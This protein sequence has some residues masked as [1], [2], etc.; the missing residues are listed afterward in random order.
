VRLVS[1]LTDGGL[2]AGVV[3]G[4]RVVEARQAL[5]RAGHA[6]ADSY[7]TVRDL[8]GGPEGTLA[9]LAKA[10]EEHAAELGVA[11]DGLK[12]GPPVADPDKVICVG[13]NYQEHAA[14]AELPVPDYPVLFPKFPSCLIGSGDPFELLEI[15]EQWDFEAELAV[16]IG[17]RATAVSQD[18]AL[19]HVAGY[20]PFNDLSARDVQLRISQWMTGKAIDDSGPCGPELVLAD[21]VPDPQALE[22]R[23]RLNGET[24]QEANTSEMVFP[25]ADLIEY[26]SS[27]ITLEPGDIIATGTPAGVGFKRDP[28]VYLAAGDRLE[29]EIEGLGNL[30]TPI[31]ASG[32]SA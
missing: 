10:A 7:L 18:A 11:R 1:F 27:Y 28:P 17:R 8:L 4:D 3:S 12:L 20:M 29:T 30:I 9:A 13:L 14:E 16:V 26:I 5:V 22:I 15:S 31:V 21:E 2:R 32:R 25:V 19:D 23:L 24:L 6:D